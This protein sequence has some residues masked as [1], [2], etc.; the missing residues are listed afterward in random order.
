MNLKKERKRRR[1]KKH[2]T[3]FSVAHELENQQFLMRKKKTIKA[4]RQ[5]K[6]QALIKTKYLMIT[7]IQWLEKHVLMTTFN[8]V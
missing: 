7:T 6:K 8:N 4:M 2:R 1:E 3:V 5:L